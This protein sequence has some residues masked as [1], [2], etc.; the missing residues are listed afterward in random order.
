MKKICCAV[1]LAVLCSGCMSIWSLQCSKDE[2]LRERI[3][4]SG[5]RTGIRMVQAGVSEDAA[6]RAVALEGGAGIGV[7]VA[8]LDALSQH[9]IRQFGAAL[10]DAGTAFGAY[11]GGRALVNSGN[12]NN[13]PNQT[14]GRD[15]NVITITGKGNNVGDK[16]TTATTT[17][18]TTP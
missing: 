2:I 1:L 8:N 15:I 10:L 3:L 7:D 6:I 12:G 14:A 5:N 16:T 17:T 4:A 18:T 11:L 13:T 9:P